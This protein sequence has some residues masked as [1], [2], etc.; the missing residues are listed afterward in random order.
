MNEYKIKY[1]TELLEK[2]DELG[3]SPRHVLKEYSILQ[4]KY[5]PNKRP[6][7]ESSKKAFEEVMNNILIKHVK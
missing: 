2:A 4:V 6:T 3:Y 5:S 7:E 1:I